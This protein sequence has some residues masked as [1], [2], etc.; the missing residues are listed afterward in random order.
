MFNIKNSYKAHTLSEALSLL[1][2]IP[3]AMVV[4]GGT[5]VLPQIRATQ[6]ENLSL[7]Y[8]GELEEL[9]GIEVRDD[10]LI[11]GA[12]ETFND[13]SRSQIIREYANALVISSSL[14]GGHEIRNVATLGGNL[15]N[16][17][18]SADS[19]AP[20]LVLDAILDVVGP[21]Y[22]REISIHDFYLAPGK[23]AL[24]HGEIL[25]SVQ[26]PSITADTSSIYIKH[27][28]RKAMEI[29][30]LGCAT[31][32]KVSPDK[33]RLIS[34]NIALTLSGPIPL[35]CWKTEECLVDAELTTSLINSIGLLVKNEISP[36]DSWRAS[37]DYRLRVAMEL[38]R[39][40][41]S[42]AICLAGGQI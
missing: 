16:G 6:P 13:I 40:A 20:L 32:V 24:L 4:C 39:R 7:I 34:A 12:G 14:V 9:K 25:R 22:V 23:T 21:N 42:E 26:L 2:S 17:V 8:I 41:I 15:C 5:D 27:G 10:R 33:R 11:V 36:R 30:T 19:I 28:R 35:R 1:I 37:K 31:A 29:S 38:S 18:V 3:E